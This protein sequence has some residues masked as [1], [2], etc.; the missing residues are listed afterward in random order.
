[1][2]VCVH[3]CG[4]MGCWGTD[5]IAQLGA[6]VQGGSAIA[7]HHTT[8][9]ALFL[10]AAQECLYTCQLPCN[11]TTNTHLPPRHLIKFS[12][13]LTN[14]H[15]SRFRVVFWS[16]QANSADGLQ[17]T[18]RRHSTFYP[19][20]ELS[21]PQSEQEDSQGEILPYW[22]AAHILSRTCRSVHAG[23]PFDQV[24]RKNLR[25]LLVEGVHC[26][27]LTLTSIPSTCN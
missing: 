17:S 9:I 5:V 11:H 15:D 13:Q 7:D 23:L 21:G 10:D 26:V 12:L 16:Q 2:S 3:V 4:W 19:G 27:G 1:M 6:Q 25:L 18:A 8:V 22:A 20:W 14:N 24:N